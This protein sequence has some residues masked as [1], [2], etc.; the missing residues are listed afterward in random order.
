[1]AGQDIDSDSDG[2]RALFAKLDRRVQN[3]RSAK[4]AL[5]SQVRATRKDGWTN[6]RRAVFLHALAETC[7]VQES[8]RLV[9]MSVSSAYDLRKRDPGFAMLWEEAKERGYERIELWVMNQIENGVEQVETIR[10][11]LGPDAK[12]K[13]VKTIRRGALG[14]AIRLLTA[15][16]TSIARYRAQR[17]GLEAEQH[18]EDVR[19]GVQARLDSVRDHLAE[20]EARGRALER[21]RAMGRRAGE[22]G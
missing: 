22:D 15:H 8:A 3:Y 12:V 16:Q 7:N 1:M 4:G 6:R 10:D 17:A 5:Q 13:S 9:K 2:D 21:S 19:D 20:N 18:A 11:G 14:H